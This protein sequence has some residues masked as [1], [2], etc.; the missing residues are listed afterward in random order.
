[1]FCRLMLI[2]KCYPRAAT[3]VAGQNAIDVAGKNMSDIESEVLALVSRPAGPPWSR[4][5]STQR[6]DLTCH[7]TRSRLYGL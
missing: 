6:E 2:E 3:V 5:N 7:N 4:R 1:M